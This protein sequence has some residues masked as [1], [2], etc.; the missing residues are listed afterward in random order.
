MVLASQLPRSDVLLSFFGSRT[1]SLTLSD[2][3]CAARPSP[4]AQNRPMHC[5]PIAIWK[6]GKVVDV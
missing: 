4:H 3:L 2:A 5:T 6:D 1:N